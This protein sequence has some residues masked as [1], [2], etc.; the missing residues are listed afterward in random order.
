MTNV[1]L[2]AVAMVA[3]ASCRP[4]WL[5]DPHGRVHENPPARSGDGQGAC[6][7][8]RAVAGIGNACGDNCDCRGCAVGVCAAAR[9]GAAGV[10]AADPAAARCL[11]P[12]SE[13]LP[14]CEDGICCWAYA[15]VWQ[16]RWCSI[17][18]RVAGC[19][20]A[21]ECREPLFPPDDA[22]S[23]GVRPD[24]TMDGG[25]DRIADAGKEQP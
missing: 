23:G 1:A 25:S 5:D 17:S 19:V 10:S 4:W 20:P 13:I 3:M 7:P 14:G 12:C 9:G 24:A 2:A 16:G 21:S 22:G 15:P 8:V 11:V 18:S 6:A